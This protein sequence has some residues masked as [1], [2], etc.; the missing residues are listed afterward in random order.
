M[1]KPHIAQLEPNVRE[2]ISERWKHMLTVFN[3]NHHY[4]GYFSLLLRKR[5]E[6]EEDELFKIK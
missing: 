1:D 3:Q 5:L 4:L 2:V 6:L